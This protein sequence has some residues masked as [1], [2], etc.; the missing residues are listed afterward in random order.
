MFAATSLKPATCAH[1]QVGL[2]FYERHFRTVHSVILVICVSC[3]VLQQ[4][5]EHQ[6]WIHNTAD[7]HLLVDALLYIVHQ[8]EPHEY[9][10]VLA[11]MVGGFS[12]SV[13]VTQMRLTP[14]SLLDAT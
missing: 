4:L 5:G 1:L 3:K 13:I 2:A 10:P 11:F 12:G 7:H 9:L 6:G 14:I 8:D